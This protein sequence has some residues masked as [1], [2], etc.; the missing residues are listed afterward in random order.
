MLAIKPHHFVDIITAFG[1]G[2]ETFAPHP[3]GHALHEVAA[4]ILA[5]RD[6]LLRM[7]LGADAI[8]LPCTHNVAS[9]SQSACSRLSAPACAPQ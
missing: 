9:A 2:R 4:E 5:A 3:Y 7:E 8:C 1:D 6:V